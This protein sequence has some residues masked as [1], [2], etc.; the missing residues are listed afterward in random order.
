M[1]IYEC[2]WVN[3]SKYHH[4]NDKMLVVGGSASTKLAMDLATQLNAE[5]TPA[6][7]K[8]FPD[9]ECY[10]RIEKESLDDDV[11][12]VQNSYPDEKLVELLLLQDAAIGLDARKVTNVI[13]YYG[14]A[15]QDERFNKGEPLSAKVMVDHIQM[16][17][18]KVVLV[19]IHNNSMLDWFDEAEVVDT[20]AA[21][22]IGRFYK[23]QGIDLVLAPDEGALKRA[24]CVAEVLNCDW[25]YLVKTR[26]S[27]TNVH[28]TPKNIDAKNK[29][30]LIVDD[31]ISTG[32]T[33]VA[34][35][36]ELRRLGARSVNAAC[37]HGLFVGGALDRLK[38]YCDKIAA[39]NTLESEV[40]IISVAPEVAK[41]I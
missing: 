5:Y 21:P 3:Y 24:G 28:M 37:T 38:K 40:S 17:A 9:G 27:G 39:A 32:G 25:D 1:G 12:I 31:I 30:V 11:V 14:Y 20:H 35:T 23:D 26:L 6:T 41:A 16:N 13:P 18:D 4:L 7:V 29:K 34:A 36:E 8:R 19:D 33:I 2:D 15:R 10:V 22:A